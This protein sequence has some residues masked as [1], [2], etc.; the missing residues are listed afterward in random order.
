[1]RRPLGDSRWKK[2]EWACMDVSKE[3]CMD[4]SKEVM[5]EGAGKRDHVIDFRFPCKLVE[6]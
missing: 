2:I 5:V 6:L 4:V 1:M 3:V